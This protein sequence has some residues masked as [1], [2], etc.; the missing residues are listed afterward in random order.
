MLIQRL[1]GDFETQ[2]GI[3]YEFD[4][5]SKPVG[6]GGMG[7]VFRG[8]KVV[9]NT[10]VRTPVAIKAMFDDLPDSVIERARREASIKFRNDNLVEMLGFVESVHVSSNGIQTTHYHVISEFLNGVMLSDLLCGMVTDQSGYEIPY[11]KT[12][13]QKYK[14][15]RTGFSIFIIKNI[16]F[17]IMALHDKGY[18]HRDI[19][20][21]NIMITDKECIKIIDFGIAKKIVFSRKSGQNADFYW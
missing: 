19:D 13:Y 6:V 8:E 4:L 10:G 15:D 16:L 18:I 2:Q 3:F 14:D 20:P 9:V 21:S 5:H 7:K 11:A 12:L 1:Q 17:G